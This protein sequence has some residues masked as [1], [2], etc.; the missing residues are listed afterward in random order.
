ML[1]LAEFWQCT[2]CLF[3]VW[4]HNTK[5][6]VPSRS[7]AYWAEHSNTSIRTSHSTK[8]NLSHRSWFS[9]NCLT[10]ITVVLAVYFFKE[11]QSDLQ[12]GCA[13]EHMGCR[14]CLWTQ[15]LLILGHL[16]PDLLTWTE[17]ENYQQPELHI[18]TTEAELITNSSTVKWNYPYLLTLPR[19]KKNPHT[20]NQ[21]GKIFLNII[22]PEPLSY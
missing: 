1:A 14:Q 22:C 20:Q 18:K 9:D 2:R 15:G 16:N 3:Q 13:E 10:Q 4:E 12:Q 5:L 7:V 17:R 19:E 6:H 11:A 8:T 21:P